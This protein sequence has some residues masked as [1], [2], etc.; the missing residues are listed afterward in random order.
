M[1]QDN[2]YEV[3]P[4]YPTENP[5]ERHCPQ[6]ETQLSLNPTEILS[7]EMMSQRHNSHN[8]SPWCP[9][10][11]HQFSQ[12]GPVDPKYLLF[13][14]IPVSQK[15]NAYIHTS[16]FH[17]KRS[18]SAS[19]VAKTPAM[20]LTP[21]VTQGPQNNRESRTYKAVCISETWTYSPLPLT[22]P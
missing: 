3:A 22:H 1:L 11:K 4:A 20:S 18:H 17:L 14:S 19:K 8:P 10:S 12:R 15:L 13:R 21:V 7:T 2:T 5:T 9:R 6:A 16:S